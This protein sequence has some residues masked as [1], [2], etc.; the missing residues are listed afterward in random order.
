MTNYFIYF[1]FIEGPR[2]LEAYYEEDD[3]VF[4]VLPF[5]GTPVE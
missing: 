5:N 1:L 2:S 3:E 4:S